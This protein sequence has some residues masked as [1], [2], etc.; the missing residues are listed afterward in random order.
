MAVKHLFDTFVPE[1]YKVFLDIDRKTKTIK[2]KTAVT[3]EA[4]ELNISFHA[5]DLH[6]SKV[7]VFSVNTNF[8]ENPDNEEIIVNVGQKGQVTISFEYETKLTDNMMGIYPSYYE[9]DGVK[10]QLIGTQFE[11]HFAR[12]A[13]PCIDEPEAKATF[14]LSVKFDEE[15]GDIIIANMPELMEIEGIHVFQRT[16][17]M[18]SY[19]LAFVF[20]DMQAKYGKTKTG[21]TVGTFSTKAHKP[22]ALDFPLEIAIA[23]I[24]FYEDYY[25]TP[26]PLPHSWHV[27][28][29]DFSAGAME[30]WGCI[31]YREVCMLVDPDNATEASKQYVA[32]VIAH[33]LAHQWFGDLVTMK[34]WDDLWLNESFANNMEYVAIDA[35]HPEWNIWESFSTQEAAMALERDATD[36]VQSVHVEVTH[37]DEINSLFDPAI[38]YAKGSRLMVMLRK[39]LGDKD[40]SAGLHLYFETNKYGNTTGDDL[41]ASLSEVSGK[42]VAAFMHSWVNQPGYPVVDAELKDGKLIL[43]QHQFFIGEGEDKERLWQIP[44]DANYAE[45]PDVFGEAEVEVPNFKL[46]DGKPLLLNADNAAHYI[47]NYHGELLDSILA[48]LDKLSNL[49]KF[50]ILQDQKFLAKGGV[51]DFAA[52]IKLLPR[53]AGEDSY[54]VN[55][56]LSDILKQISI[57][58]DADTVAEKAFNKLTEKVFAKQYK[59]LGWE[60]KEGESSSDEALRSIVLSNM[61]NAKSADAVAEA[62]KYFAVQAEDIPN[63]PA[64]IRPIVLRNEIAASNSPELV[65][66]YMNLYVKTSIQELKGELNSAASYIKDQAA[67]DELLG[68]MMNADIIKPQDVAFSWRYLMQHDFSQDAAWKWMRDN[69][70]WLEEKLS[71]DM[72]FDRFIVDS[73]KIFKTAEKLAEFKAFFEPMMDNAGISRAIGLSIKQIEARAALVDSQKAAVEAAVTATEQSF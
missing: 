47:I 51:I 34:W 42:D 14:D 61:I 23:S 29:P 43:K 33:E 11:S 35:I 3:G 36:G 28:L 12:Q 56:A 60:K 66:K 40:F 8:I 48:N 19:L 16:V 24:D 52:L 50:Q 59:R 69:W 41:W 10:K 71:G 9:V 6:F 17:R 37:P 64:N 68:D 5:K 1:N 31:T 4:K 2:G 73:G 54:I 63:I 49:E 32:T 39:W 26:Y 13:F 67:V 46:K 15:P 21:V 65:Q 70:G 27:A 72:S 22:E 20:G 7:R 55:G 45:L 30:N 38:V 18:S 53:F 62:R 57:F 44:L 58:I 25:K